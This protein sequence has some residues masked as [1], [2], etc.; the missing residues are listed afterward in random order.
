MLNFEEIKNYWDNRAAG[1]SSVQSTTQDVY[2][3]QIELS[4]LKE[5]IAKIAPKT[6][7]DIGSGD[8]RTTIGLACAFSKIDFHGFDYS[9]PMVENS[10]KIAE[11]SAVKNLNFNQLDVCGGLGGA[12]D[13]IY[14]TRCLINIPSWDLQRQAIRNIYNA[15]NKGGMYFMIENFVEGQINFNKIRKD[16]NLP[17]IP[18]REHNFFFERESL[19]DFMNDMFAVVE[20]VNISSA[21]YLMTRI[22][23]AKTC[24]DQGVVPNYFDAQHKY[25][26][27][28]PFCG[29]FGPVRIICFQKK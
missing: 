19:L 28:L 18:I 23:Y 5:R 3:R 22:V 15:L 24:A 6:V 14:T 11:I 25:A 26:A 1:D 20:D 2:L 27:G 21:Y 4:V 29:D 12:Y 7:A 16:F 17:E 8:G 13:L 9:F 10:R